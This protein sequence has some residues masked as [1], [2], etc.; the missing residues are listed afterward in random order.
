MK[1]GKA[2]TFAVVFASLCWL[3]SAGEIVVNYSSQETEPNDTRITAGWL[4]FG[5]DSSPSFWM[6]ADVDYYRLMIT[7]LPTTL[8]VSVVGVPGNDPAARIEDESGGTI[9]V[10]AVFIEQVFV[11]TGTYYVAVFHQDRPNF[12][13]AA[14]SYT[15]SG[16]F[17]Q[18]DDEPPTY[19]ATIGIQRVER[20]GDD[21]VSV[22]WSPAVDNFTPIHSARRCELRGHH[23]CRY[24]ERHRPRGKLLLWRARSRSRGQR[25]RE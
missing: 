19:T 5:G 3:A 1:W 10:P 13:P 6:D 12:N 9:A 7:T 25:G 21:S 23:Q 4:L 20:G 11:T 2:T 16:Q 18:R 22:E 17:S 24:S 14:T 15:L 8:T